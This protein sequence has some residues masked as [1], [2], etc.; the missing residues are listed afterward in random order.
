MPRKLRRLPMEAN[1]ARGSV[2]GP[3]DLAQDGSF[4]V[5]ENQAHTRKSPRCWG[6][7]PGQAP[8]TPVLTVEEER[9]GAL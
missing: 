1:A 3:E 5:W 7:N 2:P 6:W 9:L 4:G 8:T